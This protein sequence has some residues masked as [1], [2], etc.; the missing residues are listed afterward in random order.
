MSI[1]T[2]QLDKWV[3]GFHQYY[4]D[5]IVIS[6]AVSDQKLHPFSVYSKTQSSSD[7]PFQVWLCDHHLHDD[8]LVFEEKNERFEIGREGLDVI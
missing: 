4:Y 6:Y 2:L 1:I 8:V 5:P 3:K 7:R